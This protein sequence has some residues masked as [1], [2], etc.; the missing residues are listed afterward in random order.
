MRW[1]I[2]ACKVKPYMQCG[3]AVCLCVCRAFCTIYTC[4]EAHCFRFLLEWGQSYACWSLHVDD[5]QGRIGAMAAMEPTLYMYFDHCFI[6]H[7]QTVDDALGK[8]A[9]INGPYL[10]DTSCAKVGHW[11]WSIP[12]KLFWSTWL[13]SMCQDNKL[14][15][16]QHGWCLPCTSCIQYF[17]SLSTALSLWWALEGEPSCFVDIILITRLSFSDSTMTFPLSRATTFFSIF[18]GLLTFGGLPLFAWRLPQCK[19]FY[20]ATSPS[21]WQNCTGYLRISQN[22]WFNPILQVCLSYKHR[23]STYPSCIIPS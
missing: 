3:I 13:S 17:F 11:T 2:V 15:F 4:A 12:K 6:H 16:D 10:I 19:L 14:S 1:S 18:L 21:A 20:Q 23:S 22:K 9:A 5:H 8:S 7:A